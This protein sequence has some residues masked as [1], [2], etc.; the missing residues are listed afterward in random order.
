MILYA[1]VAAC[2]RRRGLVL[3]SAL[4]LVMAGLWTVQARL[5]VNTD[6]G[7]LFSAALPWKQRSAEL[8]QAFPQHADVL[9]AVVDAAVPEAAEITAAELAAA[10][11]A[12]PAHVTSVSRPGASP[13]LDRNAF[14]FLPLETLQQVLDSTIAAQPFLG[15]LNADPSLRGLCKALSLTA[16]GVASGQANLQPFLP[17]LRSLHVALAAAA[18]GSLVPL[19]W[20]RLLAGP[21]ADL[22]GRYSFV[23][24]KPRS[25]YGALQPGGIA[26]QAVRDAAARLEFVRDGGARVRLT[27]SVA[28]DDEEFATVAKGASAGLVGSLL[29]VTLWLTLAVRDVAGHHP[30]PPDADAGPAADGSVRGAHSEDT[31]PTVNR[32]CHPVCGHRSRLRDPVQRAVPRGAPEGNRPGGGAG[33]H[34]AAGRLPDPDRRTGYC[35]RI[36]GVHADSLHRRGPARPDRRR[37]HADLPL[38]VRL[39]CCRRCWRRSGRRARR[40]PGSACCGRSTRC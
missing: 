13:F 18:R 35:G 14:L 21:V 6:T 25:D 27:G 1:V 7:S 37:R 28:L 5:G 17:A 36:S 39:P 32:L 38:P 31:E 12:D 40:R 24:I 29:L 33:A 11:A 19:S 23:L 10:A 34:R 9:V 30:H 20:E 26:S 16:D 15:E 3:L 22:A 4:L 2:V 8:E